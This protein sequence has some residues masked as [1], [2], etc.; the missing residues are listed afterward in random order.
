MLLVF[1][2]LRDF[3]ACVDKGTIFMRVDGA[4][5]VLTSF[6]H[7]SKYSDVILPLVTAMGIQ[8]KEPTE[9]IDELQEI[10]EP[11][12]RI[13]MGSVDV[14]CPVNAVN[15]IPFID[16]D[17]IKGEAEEAKVLIA[18]DEH[19]R[20][21]KERDDFIKKMKLQEEIQA[22]T[23]SRKPPNRPDKPSRPVVTPGSEIQNMKNM[24]NLGIKKKTKR[25]KT[26]PLDKPDGNKEK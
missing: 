16:V 23:K 6:T 9:L 21:I 22:L 10:F 25:I 24:K 26:P 7:V 4:C 1:D 12:W 11:D 15:V 2:R 5:V 19:K 8:G 20:D 14:T 17:Q 13:Y 18:D 3:L